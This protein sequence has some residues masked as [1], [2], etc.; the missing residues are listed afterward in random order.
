MNSGITNGLENFRFIHEALPERDLS[1]IK[2]TRHF[3]NKE[4]SIPLM[5]SSMTGGT[6]ESL[7]INRALA[8]AAQECGV[9]LGLGSQRAM[10]E[11]PAT[12]YTYKVR[13]Y[14]PDI[15]LFA[16]IGAVQLNQGVTAKMCQMLVDSVEADGLILHLNALQEAIQNGGNTN[17]SGLLAKI[18]ELCRSI[19][20]PVIV[21]EVGWGISTKSACQLRD[22]GISAIDVAGAGGT[23]W[24]QVEMHQNENSP[25]AMVASCFRDWGIS[26][27]D[28]IQMV[29][30]AAP[31]IPI[32]ASGGLHNG[33]EIAKCLCLGASLGGIARPFFKA[34]VNGVEAVISMINTIKEQMRIAMFSIGAGNI[35]ELTSDKLIE[36][37]K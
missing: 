2:L 18:E 31:D 16:N 9:A 4:L 22:C 20:T 28:S 37:R 8:Q 26:T 11:E 6:E 32:I 17:F 14:A 5:I 27:A 30:K 36:A 1:S 12:A 34:A 33:V 25:K 15:L 10:L 29:R 19:H 21:K 35:Q 24:S 3:F 13:S 23:S 7:P